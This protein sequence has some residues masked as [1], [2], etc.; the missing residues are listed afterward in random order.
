MRGHPPRGYYTATTAKRR[1]GDITDGKLR[2]YVQRGRIERFVPDGMS[3]GFY[4]RE[5]VDRIANQ[6]D[7]MYSEPEGPGPQF[8]IATEQDMQ[9]T[10]NLL[11]EAFGGGDTTEKRIEWLRRNP[12]IAF[13]ERSTVGGRVVGCVFVLPL[14]DEKIAQLLDDPTPSTRLITDDDIQPYI[15]GQPV[16]LF[17]VGMAVKAKTG[18]KVKR[19]RGGTMLRGMLRFLLNAGKRGIVIKSI[20]ARSQSRDGINLLHGIGFTEI[21][22]TTDERNFIIEVERSG[23]PLLQPYKRALAQWRTSHES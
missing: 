6:L 5:D 20:V 8:M 17:V 11:I 23:I 21:V 4:K 7:E 1:L 14:T 9:E 16:S 10:V 13:I 3:Q 19:A 15:P 2:Y 12:E 18:L 22:S